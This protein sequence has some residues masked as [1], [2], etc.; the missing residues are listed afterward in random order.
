[1]I[2]FVIAA[3]MAVGTL[4]AVPADAKPGAFGITAIVAILG[5]LCTVISSFNIVSTRNVGIVTSFGK[6]VGERHAGVAWVA[7]WQRVSEMDAAIQLQS[8]QGNSYDD[9]QSAVKVRLGNNSAAFVESNLNWRIKEDAAGKMFQDYRTFDNIRQNL[10]DKQ[11]Q[12][13]LSKEFAK[14]NPQT[15]VDTVDPNV[16]STAPA[17]NQGADLPGIAATVKADL[18]HAVGTEIEIIDVRIPGIFYDSATQQR[19]DAFNQKVQE[20]KNAQ[21]DVQTATQSRLASEQ[22]ANQAPPDLKVAIFNCI[23]TLVEQGKD[24]AG[25]WGQPGMNNPNV[26]LQIP[27]RS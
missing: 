13:A 5:L 11:L 12:V 15:Q 18:Q 10:V 3:L 2:F 22:R 4:V 6:P 27:P 8:F 26:I 17:Q 24:P 7:P 21:Q 25:C 23:N 14:F 9:P 19:I 1:L 16:P 20:T